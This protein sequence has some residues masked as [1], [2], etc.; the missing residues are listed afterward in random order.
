[1]SQPWGW[2]S[3]CSDHP[4]PCQW[5]RSEIE[6]E[7]DPKHE[8]PLIAV[9]ET[10][11]EVRR[12]LWHVTRPETLKYLALYDMNRATQAQREVFLDRVGQDMDTF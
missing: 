6:R 4:C 7:R 3:S 1:M 5:D 9:A 2:T 8:A 12:H 10:V 11:D